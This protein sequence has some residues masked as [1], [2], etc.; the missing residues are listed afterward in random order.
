VDE[1]DAV[2]L[3]LLGVGGRDEEADVQPG[4]A[5]AAV[6]AQNQGIIFPPADRRSAARKT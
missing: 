4:E 3:A 1:D 2:A 6:S 5:E